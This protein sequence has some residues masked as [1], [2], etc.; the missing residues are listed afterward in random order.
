[1]NLMLEEDSRS[2]FNREANRQFDIQRGGIGFGLVKELVQ[3]SGSLQVLDVAP[4]TFFS[5]ADPYRPVPEP[6]WRYA[7]V[8]GDLNA[9]NIV[10]GVDTTNLDR[11]FAAVITRL[12]KD[13]K[14]I[15]SF[16][17][18]V[19][20]VLNDIAKVLLINEATKEQLDSQ[21][22]LEVLSN[23]G[24]GEGDEFRCEVIRLRGTTTLQLHKLPRKSVPKL[25]VDEIRAKHRDQWN[26]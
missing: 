2:Q 25:R 13:G 15:A 20:S 5:P 19:E 10:V 23:N 14:T 12:R 22:D 8:H 1:M 16:V 17:G 21:C 26:F 9:A 24:I 6:R 11:I 7:Q 3:I 4:T 18:R